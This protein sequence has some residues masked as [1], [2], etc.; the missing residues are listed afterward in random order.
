MANIGL[1]YPVCATLSAHTAGSEP[2]YASTGMVMG[3]GIS[4]N[5]TITRNTNVLY[6]DDVEVENDNG[7]TA[8][9]IELGLD[10]L[11]LAA[12]KYILGLVEKMTSG[13]GS[14]TVDY[15][16]ETDASAPYV[17][18]GYIR[19]LQVSGVKKFFGVWI[20][21]VTFSKESETVQTKGESVE[22]QTPV[23]NGR[24][25]GL[26]VDGSGNYAFRKIKE[27]TTESAAKTWLN[28]LAG[29]S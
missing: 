14:S 10:N 25:M 15:Y 28:N 9:S 7:I 17:G 11:T 24:C 26:D 8:M 12:E 5:L 22:W 3:H 27:F 4:A 13:S 23:L 18:M 1:R 16:L 21:K 20:Y 2:T 6:G 19:V 29:I